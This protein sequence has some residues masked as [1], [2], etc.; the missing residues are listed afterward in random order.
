MVLSEI[1]FIRALSFTTFY[2]FACLAIEFPLGL[3]IAYIVDEL[4]EKIKKGL[5]A[6]TILLLLPILLP[7][8]STALIFSIS[9]NDLVGIIPHIISIISGQKG[10][11][12]L[13]DPI[14]AQWTLILIDVW[15][16]TPFFFLL[17]YSGLRMLPREITEAAII[18]GASRAQILRFIKLPLLK[19]IIAIVI[20]L[21]GLWLFR[22]FEVQKLLTGGGPGTSTRT[23]SMQIY[24]YAFKQ[25]LLGLAAASTVIIFLVI[26]IVVLIY[27][28]IILK[29]A[30]VTWGA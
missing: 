30:G 22:S 13:S 5:K 16:W 7:P 6:I 11:S 8:A 17:L 2:T 24:E 20:T 19:N 18:D 10:I 21:R 14:R 28:R 12:L 3:F 1:L 29:R 26:N 27:Q 4:A 25:G 23:I 15:Q 9:L